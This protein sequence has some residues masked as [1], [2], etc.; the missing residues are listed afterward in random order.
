MSQLSDRY[1]A[2]GED[3]VSANMRAHTVATVRYKVYIFFL[4]VFLVFF[5]PMVTELSDKLRWTWSLNK[6]TSLWE[7]P[8]IVT[9]LL[10]TR[11]EWWILNDIDA[12]KEQ[13]VAAEKEIKWAQIITEIIARLNEP[14]KQNTMINCLNDWFCDDIEPQLIPFLPLFRT[15]LLVWNLKWKKMEFNQKVILKNIN[16]FLLKTSAWLDNASLQSV[17]FSNPVLVDENY[18]LYRIPIQLSIEFQHKNM[19]ASF[20]HNIEDRVSFTIPILYKIEALSYNIV[21]YNQPQIVQLSLDAYYI[22]GLGEIDKENIKE[23]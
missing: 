17:T 18:S 3:V 7:I 5:R 11:G 19:L 1:K 16:D 2:E 23:E 4:I 21:E 20:L 12:K 8:N 15:Y 10:H 9:N 22:E 6:V 14:W 13:I